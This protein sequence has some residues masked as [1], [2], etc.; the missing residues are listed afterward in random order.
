MPRVPIAQEHKTN[1]GGDRFPK[2]KPKDKGEKIRFTIVETPWREHVHYLKAPTFDDDTGQP[3]K[4]RKEKRDGT[5][6][7]DYKLEFVSA[8]ICLGDEATLREKG[9]DPANCPACEAAEKSGGDIPGPIQRFAVNVVQYVLQGNTWN[10]AKPFSASIKIWAFTGRQ[11]DEV[12]GIQEEIGD[13]RRHD[14][15]L[16]CDD[17]YWQRNKISFKM[18]PGY[19][20]GD[21]AY[22]KELLNTPGNK[23]TDDQ[24]RDAC[25]RALPRSR[26]EDDCTYTLRQWR[27]LRVEGIDSPY[28]TGTGA[29]LDGGIDG[30]LSEEEG[31]A[32]GAGQGS[33]DPLGEFTAEATSNPGPAAG[34]G[35]KAAA[36]S[37]TSRSGKARERAA[38]A[39]ETAARPSEENPPDGRFFGQEESAAET[40]GSGPASATSPTPEAETGSGEG[41]QQARDE[42]AAEVGRRAAAKVEASKQQAA[43]ENAAADDF[44][45]DDLLEGIGD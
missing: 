17:P 36:S 39:E 15:T 24:L 28:D 26:M 32:S 13:L 41:D 37:R 34:A 19:K 21:A 2:I 42:V 4:E 40:A 23:A 25:G 27:R 12:E 11:Y 29:D 6:Y 18:D 5:P 20:S 43:T 3:L 14:I 45:F 10:I 9:L 33:D 30:L 8:P 16:E 31:T 44:N 35:K 1:E 22:M 38:A 7:Y